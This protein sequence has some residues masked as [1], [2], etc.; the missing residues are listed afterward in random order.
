MPVLLSR[1]PAPLRVLRS[2]PHRAVAG[3]VALGMS[4][5]LACTTAQGAGASLAVKVE[6]VATGL[7][8]P[9]GLAFLPGGDML[10]TERGGTLRRVSQAG[11]VSPPLAGVP[12]VQA[13]SQ[14]GLL[15]VV[16]DPDFAQRPWVYLS[17]SEP[18]TGSEAGLAGTAVARARLQGDRL[19]DVQVIFRQT[20]KVRGGGHFGSRLVFG[21][22]GHLFVTLGDRMQDS[23][24]APGRDF[25]QNLQTTLGKVVRIQRDGRIPADNP[26]WPGGAQPGIWST[27]HRNPQG[28]ALHP[29][30]GEL[31]VVEHGPQGGDEL[32][33]A[34]PGRNFGWP[35]RSY[36][37]PYGSLTGNERCRVQGGVHAPDFTEPVSTWVPSVSPS[38][39]VFYTGDRYPGW[40][41]SLFTGALSGRALWRL[42]LQGD[43]VVTREAL[44]PDLRERIRDVRQGPDGWLYLLTDSSEGRIVRLAP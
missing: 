30:T 24:S 3:M 19:V 43:R 29:D 7:D 10:V 11:R 6:T 33:R 23:P 14:G 42:V 37:C 21:R 9:W 5:L 27:G 1:F 20:P 16:V 41:G 8:T 32:N 15:D 44:L 2:L 36:G 13:R 12:A 31:W 34:L 17:Y 35:L 38:G 18:G 39:L 25:A 28:A 40:K 22:D 4:A 26:S